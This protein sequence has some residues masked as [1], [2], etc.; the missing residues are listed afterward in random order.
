M[1]GS[2]PLQAIAKACDTCFEF[3]QL[4][5]CFRCSSLDRLHAVGKEQA[6]QE[7]HFRRLAA[8]QSSLI[9]EIMKSVG[10]KLSEGDIQTEVYISNAFAERDRM[11]LEY[12]KAM[13]RIAA[14]M[15]QQVQMT[16]LLIQGAPN[17]QTAANQQPQLNGPQAAA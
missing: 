3:F 8:A 16:R 15:E 5:G 7:A 12:I 13:P 17:Q 6:A 9:F 1:S 2:T 10:L 14:A 4:S 11:N